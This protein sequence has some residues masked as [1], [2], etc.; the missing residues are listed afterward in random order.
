MKH[1][2]VTVTG[3]GSLVTVKI[4][5]PLISGKNYSASVR[6]LITTLSRKSRLR[7]MRFIATLLLQNALFVTL[8]YGQTYP[9]VKIAKLHLREFC[10]RLNRLYPNA[11]FIWRQEFQERGAVHFH[12]IITD[13]NF[14][15]KSLIMLTWANVINYVYWDFTEEDNGRFGPARPPFTRV[16][17]IDSV[18][19]LTNYVSKYLAKVSPDAGG[20]NDVPYL[21]DAITGEISAGRQWGVYYRANLNYA[22][23]VE[24]TLLY[25]D[26]YR[27]MTCAMGEIWKY[28]HRAIYRDTG[29]ALF[30]DSASVWVERALTYFRLF[31]FDDLTSLAEIH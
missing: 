31:S 3:Q 8:T 24:T 18:K 7:F 5:N 12:L 26:W 6:G 30:Y 9:S 25:G 16:E 14:I 27:H 23:I 2:Q 29:F 28:C 11:A 1:S 13:C 20:F 17:R 10:R 22:I 19:K 15:P 21:H 4:R